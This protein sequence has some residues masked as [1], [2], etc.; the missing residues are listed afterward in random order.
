MHVDEC[1]CRVQCP[2][3]IR[4]Y[5]KPVTLIRQ[6]WEP[7]SGFRS[8][9]HGLAGD[10]NIVLADR[11]EDA[12]YPVRVIDRVDGRYWHVKGH[13]QVLEDGVLEQQ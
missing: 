11:I 13:Y 1:V 8:Y 10:C 2:R 4:I 9:A 3:N 5:S 7:R 6:C 12:E